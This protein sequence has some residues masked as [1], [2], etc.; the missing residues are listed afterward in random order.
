MLVARA[1]VPQQRLLQLLNFVVIPSLQP[2]GGG[3][4]QAQWELNRRAWPGSY[5][6]RQLSGTP[7]L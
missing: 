1:A 5:A 7:A 6:A 3:N 2:P 4:G